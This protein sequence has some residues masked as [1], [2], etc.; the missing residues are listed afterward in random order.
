MHGSMNIKFIALSLRF[1]VSALVLAL[2]PSLLYFTL[3]YFTLL[4]F[5]SLL[6]IEVF[7]VLTVLTV[8]IK[9]YRTLQSTHMVQQARHCIL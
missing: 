7:T 8:R 4:Y 2:R 6:H 5:T 9:L 1:L 3:L